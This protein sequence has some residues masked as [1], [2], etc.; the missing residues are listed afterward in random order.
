MALNILLWLSIRMVI[1]MSTYPEESETGSWPFQASGKALFFVIWEVLHFFDRHPLASTWT[2]DLTRRVRNWSD[3]DISDAVPIVSVLRV[4]YVPVCKVSDQMVSKVDVP[5]PVVGT[6]YA[7]HIH[8]SLLR[9]LIR[10]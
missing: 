7:G 1:C 5:G 9:M 2:V 8:S 4:Y 3:R 6:R 10:H